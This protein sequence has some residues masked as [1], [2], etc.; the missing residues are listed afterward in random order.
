MM[1]KETIGDDNMGIQL[2][3][4]IV[5]L[6]SAYSLVSLPIPESTP[7]NTNDSFSLFSHHYQRLEYSIFFA[8]MLGLFELIQSYEEPFISL[9]DDKDA[10]QEVIAP[11]LHITNALTL[12]FQVLGILGNP[13]VTVVY[14][15]E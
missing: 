8:I 9:S 7:Y 15:L 5:I 3:C 2:L 1:H 12:I 11:I 13:L 10:L 14:F 6:F 4:T